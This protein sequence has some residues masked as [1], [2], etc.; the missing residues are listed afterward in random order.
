MICIINL[1]VEE[2]ITQALCK[3]YADTIR[4]RELI[5]IALEKVKDIFPSCLDSRLGDKGI[6]SRI[7]EYIKHIPELHILSGV[8][9]ATDIETIRQWVCA[10]RSESIAIEDELSQR[11]D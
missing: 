1:Q 2:R 11:M 6:G 3:R 5:L 10:I 7:R 9:G 4:Q 8:V